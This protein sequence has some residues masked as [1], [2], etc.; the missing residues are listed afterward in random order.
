MKRNL[1]KLTLG[2]MASTL[3][4]GGYSQCVTNSD[5]IFYTGAMDSWTVPAGVSSVTIEARGAEGGTGSSSV[6]TG[7][8]GAIMIGDFMVTPG[9]TLKVL[10]GQLPTGSNG[11][12]GGTFVTDNSNNPLIVA[13]GGGGSS[14]A[15]DDPAKHGN[16][17]TSGGNSPNGGTGG[18]SG[19]G[20]NIG[21][22]FASGAGG[23]L[24][25]D[26][27]DG[28]TGN[29]GGKSFL[30]GGTVTTNGGFGGGGSGSGYVVGG[31]GGGYSGGGGGS[32]SVSAGVGGG[33][34][35][36]N[37]GINQNNTGGTNLGD[38]MVIFTYNNYPDTSTSLIG[39]TI[40]SNETGATYQWL[41]CDNSFSIIS[42]ETGVSYTA[43]TNGNFAVEVTKNG[44]T[45][46]SACVNIN[47]IG[48]NE[49]YSLGGIDIYPNPTN[50]II[51]ITLGTITSDVNLT[52]TSVE[53]KIVYQENN[54]S[55]NKVSVDLSN[56]SKG[57]YFLK[58]EANNQ[59]KVYKV[60]KE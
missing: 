45:D 21:A 38:G 34:G 56:N 49:N 14:D 54:V 7:G 55:D 57:I 15:T 33:G 58:V 5:T 42:G 4:L 18:T 19:N 24:L 32:N 40:S 39:L 1:L 36:F 37:N 12:G 47:T 60:I 31:G 25:T 16:T 2:I 9:S 41:D 29:T 46:T 53:G 17:T 30:N 22:S 6:N 13:G 44:C 28:W 8:L 10:V 48:I 26:G 27:I 50:N 3:S 35:S 52:L 43:T 20:G 11:G 51:N 23:G 59:Y